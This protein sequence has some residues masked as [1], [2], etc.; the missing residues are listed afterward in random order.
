MR[1]AEALWSLTMAKLRPTRRGLI[2]I[3]AAAGAGALFVRRIAAPASG[4]HDTYF[5]ALNAKVKGI[6]TPVLVIDRARLRANAK[7]IVERV[8]AAKLQLRL[9]VKSLP[10]LQLLDALEANTQRYM[11][12]N[13]SMLA[14]LWARDAA[15][16]VLLGK[17][18]PIAAVRALHAVGDPWGPNTQ[19]LID[20]KE[21]LQEYDAFATESGLPLKVSL[22]LDVGLHRGGFDDV[23]EI[24]KALKGHPRLTLAGLMGYDA[25]VGKTP[26]PLE[27]RAW[28][29]VQSRYE[30]AISAVSAAGFDAKALTLNSGGSMTFARH[31]EGTA[32]NELAVGSA[33][34]SPSDFDQEP[35]QP[36]AFIATPVLKRL[37]RVD[38]PGLEAAT[39]LRSFVAPESARGLFVFGGHWLANPVSP[40]GL[41]YSG[42]YGRS[43][44]QELVVGAEGLDVQVG[45][46]VFYRPTQSEAVLNAFGELVVVDAEQPLERW[47]VLA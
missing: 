27:G 15:V 16:D 23:A 21:R 38:I 2:V 6:G 41:S 47:A 46:C 35:L 5:S 33:F 22:E 43:S 13:T 9:V 28:S 44:N 25:H 3:G 10:S 8:A 32:A 18:M 29:N 34:V 7:S 37:S 39:G 14:A 20:T 31:L 11:A 17:P 36:A 40:P 30:A 42:L 1:G 19:W 26:G 24:A 12:F 45:D 4:P